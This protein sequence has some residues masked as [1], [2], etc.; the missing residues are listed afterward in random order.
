[1]PEQAA[2]DEKVNGNRDNRYL[3]VQ[4]P[5]YVDFSSSSPT[6]ERNEIVLNFFL[7]LSAKR[8]R[9]ESSKED[10]R[11]KGTFKGLNF[12]IVCMYAGM[13]SIPIHRNKAASKWKKVGM[14]KQK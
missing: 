14:K 8:Q 9:N 1:M 13:H 11:S 12:N 10:S 3:N 2:K 6:K 4:T 5:F 7:Q